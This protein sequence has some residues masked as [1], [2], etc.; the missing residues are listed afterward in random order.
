MHSTDKDKIVFTTDCA[1]YCYKIMPFGLKIFRAT[2]QRMVKFFFKE[3]IG[4]ITKVYIDDMFV[5]S[6]DCSNHMKH[7][8]ETFS[9][10]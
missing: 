3:L 9:L 7:L 2:F 8:E 4:N 10:L 1:I 5:K 6:L